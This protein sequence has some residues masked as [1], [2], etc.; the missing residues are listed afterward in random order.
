M[1]ALQRVNR[2]ILV[3]ARV[4]SATVPRVADVIHIVI[5]YQLSL[6]HPSP[7]FLVPCSSSAYTI[8]RRFM[9]CQ[10]SILPP[11]WLTG[12]GSMS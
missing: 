8:V 1:I 7:L 2:A 6:A 11:Q 12:T 4:S 5:A 3:S 10:R 9:D